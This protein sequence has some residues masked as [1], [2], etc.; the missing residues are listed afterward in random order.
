PTEID[1][2]RLKLL[3]KQAYLALAK[4]KTPKQS[5][6]EKRGRWFAIIATIVFSVTIAASTALL[7]AAWPLPVAA[8]ATTIV[9]VSAVLIYWFS[10]RKTF[11]RMLKDIVGD[12]KWFEGWT[13]YR[14]AETG[15]KKTLTRNKKILL[16]CATGV[17]TLLSALTAAITYSF[18]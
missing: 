12:Q 13:T 3:D 15:E 4:Y 18:I 14:D 17:A 1:Q 8:A 5:K 16:G 6:L 10:T 11:P 7:C 2:D 9:F